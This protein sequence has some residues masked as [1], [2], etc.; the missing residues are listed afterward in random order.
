MPQDRPQRHDPRPA[1]QQQQQWPAILGLPDEVTADR[2]AQLQVVPGPQLVGEIRRD[3][4]VIEPFDGDRHRLAGR[5]R[6]RVG[7]LGH[8]AVL[9]GQ[10]DVQVLPGLVAGP[11]RHVE[12]ERPHR[13]GLDRYRPDLGDLPGQSPA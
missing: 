11:V 3:L 7:P 5:R 2:P 6:D 13:G 1:G 10:P 4:A 8:V 9:V 12:R